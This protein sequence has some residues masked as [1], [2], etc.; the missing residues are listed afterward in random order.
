MKDD[1]YMVSVVT[2]RDKVAEFCEALYEIGVLGVTVTSVD[3]YGTQLGHD[4]TYRGVHTLSHLHPK[5]LVETVVCEVP[6]QKVVDTAFGVLRTGAF[7]DGKISVE[8]ISRVVRV[9]TGEE[10]RAALVN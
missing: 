4:M 8:R 9:R 1:M 5:V 10:D 2:R 6:V 7:G 3:G